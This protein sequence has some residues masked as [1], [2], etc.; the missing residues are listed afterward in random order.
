MKDHMAAGMHSVVLLL[1]LNAAES[2]TLLSTRGSASGTTASA[3]S[4]VRDRESFEVRSHTQ[5][6]HWCN[7]TVPAQ[8]GRRSALQH[9]L[10]QA[11]SAQTPPAPEDGLVQLETQAATLG[12]QL[13]RERLSEQASHSMKA[14]ERASLALDLD[15]ATRDVDAL[16][17]AYDHL[18]GSKAQANP[19][20]KAA[21][22][23]LEQA[24][25]AKRQAQAKVT[26]LQSKTSSETSSNTSNLE[27]QYRNK[28]AD[29]V[30]FQHQFF[31]TQRSLD[32]LTSALE[33]ES[34][35]LADLQSVCGAESRVYERLEKHVLPI[36]RKAPSLAATESS[37]PKPAVAKP[38]AAKPAAA[39]A[40]KPAHKTAPRKVAVV[41]PAAPKPIKAKAATVA[42][43]K[44]AVKKAVAAAKAA[45]KKAVKKAAVKAA[46]T[47]PVVHKPKH[48]APK[49]VAPKPMGQK[50][51][52][53]VKPAV[54]KPVAKP[55]AQKHKSH[56]KQKP[57][58]APVAQKKPAVKAK[59]HKKQKPPPAPV[60]HKKTQHKPAKKARKAVAKPPPPPAPTTPK[61]KDPFADDDDDDTVAPVA[62]PVAAVAK[63]VEKAHA[64]SV[65][66][67]PKMKDPF[68]DDDDDDT[69]APAV[70]PAAKAKVAVAPA[71]KMKDP[72]ADDDDDDAEAAP[73]PPPKARK[74]KAAPVAPKVAPV[75]LDQDDSDDA[76]PPSPPPPHK[77]KQHQAK[78]SAKPQKAQFMDGVYDSAA[79]NMPT[80]Y[81]AWKPAGAAS[82][83]AAPTSVSAAAAK[84]Q[85][86]SM[87]GSDDDD[88]TAVPETPAPH[89]AKA[90][91]TPKADAQPP[92]PKTKDPFADDSDDDVD[93]SPKP[94]AKPAKVNVPP[95]APKMKDPFADDSDD[96]SVSGPTPVTKP[97]QASAPP[98]AP[99]VKDPF[100]DDD[101][102]T[103][104]S[105]K[106]DPKPAKT[107]FVDA[108]AKQSRAAAAKAAE[109]AFDS[110]DD[111]FD[112]KAAFDTAKS[113]AS[114][115]DD[116]S[117]PKSKK[118]PAMQDD[119]DGDEAID[120]A[121]PEKGQSASQL[122]MPKKASSKKEKKDGFMDG[123]YDAAAGNLPGQ[124][125][126][127]SPSEQA[128]SGKKQKAALAEMEADFDDDDDDTPTPAPKKKSKHHRHAPAPAPPPPPP[129]RAQPADDGVVYDDDDLPK[130]H[131]NGMRG[132]EGGWQ[133]FM[134]KPVQKV[135][136]APKLDPDVAIMESLYTKDGG[137]PSQYTAWS[138]TEGA[139]KPVL[140]E[141]PRPEPQDDSSSDG[142]GD[143]MDL[144]AAAKA[145]AKDPDSAFDFLQVTMESSDAFAELIHHAARPKPSSFRGMMFLE[146]S[147]VSVDMSRMA[148]ASAVLE[149]YAEVLKSKPLRQLAKAKLSPPKLE[150]L[151]QQLRNVDP[152]V[153]KVPVVTQGKQAQ[154]EQ[155]C[156]YFQEHMQ[157]AAPVQ[158]AVSLVEAASNS[159]AES[160][161]K[162]AALLEEIDAR[163]QLQRTMEQDLSS[164]NSLVTLAKQGE[165]TSA[166]EALGKQLT[167]EAAMAVGASAEGMEGAHAE[168]KDLLD[169][170]IEK[171]SEV[172]EAQR[173]KLAQLKV[174]VKNADADLAQKKGKAA[175][176]QASMETARKK[177]AGITT[178]CD[179]TLDALAR[180]R[181]AG[182][183]EAH[184]IEIALK[185][186]GNE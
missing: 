84:K 128:A 173:A 44:A 175:A 64:K 70:K 184:A 82:Q 146:A 87:L 101:D 167:G 1:L 17:R 124:Y 24:Q 53:H 152:L 136:K 46:A 42:A 71:P 36:L 164:L 119:L 69:P 105:A 34:G 79:G 39:V 123:V 62:A 185:V 165:D 22:K 45:V 83:D 177:L 6:S 73:P 111:S 25:E 179:A 47:K 21:Q 174:D 98:P 5:L 143:N 170:A 58:P 144:E 122:Q 72:F 183:M 120:K 91:P 43:P 51:H 16:Q 140:A 157:A 15:D 158:K 9:L 133:A 88:S 153:G 92:A 99:K 114:G 81:S 161:S 186:L 171:R 85:M 169:M 80:G 27:S 129:P 77:R 151:Y 121:F 168:L 23:L 106:P 118:A 142:G 127:W 52:P 74:H 33:D 149:Q 109:A 48:V 20:L 113:K 145:F 163:T 60:A 97:V 50:K 56:K 180:R 96:D 12:G 134:K 138:P 89:V 8:V 68:A 13:E 159:L 75:A 31:T 54:A 35:Y 32:V 112:A 94:V 11:Q 182:H 40:H 125:S 55:V 100:A 59:A 130:H 86:M 63:P 10:L 162:Q 139:P 93:S 103:S 90:A 110:D 19:G 137:L 166:L 148:A 117:A 176:S 116:F 61:T 14:K 67:P 66:A 102:D 28:K 30:S 38:V 4:L 76:S 141:A 156:K 37:K 57:P 7:A 41:K 181:H 160:V 107:A 108:D 95:P 132:L 126:A 26:L 29:I 178:S 131:S 135:K 3:S 150:A 2:A 78:A 65:K 154:A 115:D 155:M 172:L 147:A 18:G 49:A 104:V